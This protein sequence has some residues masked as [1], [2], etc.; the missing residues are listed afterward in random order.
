[1]NMTATDTTHLEPLDVNGLTVNVLANKYVEIV[2]A[3]D[4]T[5]A[6]LAALECQFGTMDIMFELDELAAHEFDVSGVM[7]DDHF[8]GEAIDMVQDMLGRT[9]AVDTT[10]YDARIEAFRTY[11]PNTPL[12][13]ADI[14]FGNLGNPDHDWSATLDGDTVNV[15]AAGNIVHSVKL[16]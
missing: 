12:G 5:D 4:A 8:I 13:N 2:R 15:W 6:V 1:M 10:I 7:D 3:N 11:H 16:S 14:E 9:T